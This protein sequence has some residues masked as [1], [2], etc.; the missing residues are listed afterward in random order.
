MEAKIKGGKNRDKVC[1]GDRK[2]NLNK[3]KERDLYNKDK[4]RIRARE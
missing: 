3:N 4:I 2:T 1:D